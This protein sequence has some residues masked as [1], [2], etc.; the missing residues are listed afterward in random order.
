[1][2]RSSSMPIRLP[3]FFFFFLMCSELLLKVV[4]WYLLLDFNFKIQNYVRKHILIYMSQFSSPVY[5]LKY[6]CDFQSYP[7]KTISTSYE[8]KR[9]KTYVK[10][11]ISHSLNKGSTFQHTQRSGKICFVHMFKCPESYLQKNRLGLRRRH[12]D[13]QQLI[14]F[15]EGTSPENVATRN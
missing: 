15:T 1:M 5:F 11:I 8:T 4:F 10:I 2:H 6:Y 13:L 7:S 3:I 14:V 12:S 9:N